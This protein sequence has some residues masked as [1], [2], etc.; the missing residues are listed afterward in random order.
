[1]SCSKPMRDASCLKKALLRL[2]LFI[3]FIGFKTFGYFPDSLFLP[4]AD[5]LFA[6]KS[7][8]QVTALR[9]KKVIK[10]KAF[11]VRKKTYTYFM[12]TTCK[13]ID[14][15][16]STIV[17]KVRNTGSYPKYFSFTT[18]AVVV[19][20]G[21]EEEPVTMFVGAYGLYRVYFFGK[22]REE[23]SS[24]SSRYRVFC[25]DVEQKKFRK[26]WRRRVR[27]M[28]RI[29]SHDVDIFWTVEKRGE[30]SSRVSL[31]ASQS[32]T[33]RTPNWMVSIGTNKIFRGMLK[34]LEKYLTKNNKLTP[35]A[36]SSAPE[37]PVPAPESSAPAAP[38]PEPVPE[39][40]MPT[41]EESAPK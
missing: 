13:T 10:P 12:V 6:L 22:I 4:Y 18:K 40:P 39:T 31:T 30:S 27:G 28:I 1:M 24:D 17:D 11:R 15:P 29:G 5:S 16:F 41:V 33:T 25:G 21:E 8:T 7:D 26:A 19:N 38:T 9:V 36:S 23:Y 37:T 3:F 2:S 14:Q 34:D 20:D 35:G 32:F